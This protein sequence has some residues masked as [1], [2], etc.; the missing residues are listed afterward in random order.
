MAIGDKVGLEAANQADQTVRAALD[1]IEQLETRVMAES[2]KWRSVLD[3]LAGGKR[4]VIT[5][6]FVDKD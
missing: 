3:Q 6:E 1:R 5:V 4:A 2:A